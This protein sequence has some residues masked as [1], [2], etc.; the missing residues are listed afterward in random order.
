MTRAHLHA[1][2]TPSL[3]SLWKLKIIKI[4]L[5]RQNILQARGSARAP[6]FFYHHIVHEILHLL[7]TLDVFIFLKLIAVDVF[8]MYAFSWKKSFFRK[9][10]DF[11]IFYKFLEKSWIFKKIIK[12][13]IALKTSLFELWTNQK[14]CNEIFLETIHS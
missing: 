12:F 13:Q 11:S 3:I 5:R 14:N 4:W 6:N 8:E 1:R 2:R 7:D 10:F 9:M